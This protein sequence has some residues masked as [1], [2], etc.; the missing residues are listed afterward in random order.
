M[1][2]QGKVALITGGSRGI[3]R[4][5]AVEF[6]RQGAR[7]ALVGRDSA[8]LQESAAACTAAG[9]ERAALFEGDV[10]ERAAVEKIVNDCIERFGQID[11]AIANAGQSQDG[12]L[13][14]LRPEML[15]R[16]LDVNL[17]SAF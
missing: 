17:K 16:T 8:A 3:G 9:G 11:C 7:V 15:D 2:L 1:S 14:R 4:A 6:A 13:L 12:L 10:A 5:I